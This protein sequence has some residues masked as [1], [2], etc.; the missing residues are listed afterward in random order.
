[1]KNNYSIIF[2]WT[3]VVLLQFCQIL[4]SSILSSNLFGEPLL[5]W[6]NSNELIFYTIIHIGGFISFP[7]TA[8]IMF[9]LDTFFKESK[10]SL[11]QALV[12]STILGFVLMIRYIFPFGVLIISSFFLTLMLFIGIEIFQIKKIINL[13]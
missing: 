12:I 9:K 3:M 7:I 13:E 11:T 1:M 4:F 8:Y 10:I 6:I 2:L 5:I